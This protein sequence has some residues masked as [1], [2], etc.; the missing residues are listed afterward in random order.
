M[1]KVMAGQDELDST[2]A[3]APVDDYRALMK[4]DVRGL[5]LGLPRSTLRAWVRKRATPFTRP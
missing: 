2:S 4:H 3:F 1:L 5:K